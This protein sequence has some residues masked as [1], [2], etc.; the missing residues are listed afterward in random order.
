MV[1]VSSFE[2]S[3]VHSRSPTQ[4][5]MKQG[6]IEENAKTVPFYKLFSFSDS[7]DVLLMIVGSI[8]AI[9]NGLGFPLMTLL[10]GDLIDTVGRNLFTDDIVELISK[11]RYRCTKETIFQVLLG[12][13]YFILFGFLRFRFV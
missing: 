4:S 2:T 10:F 1:D 7:T 9:G 3:H 12:Y 8:G 11:V 13:V 5:E 6:R